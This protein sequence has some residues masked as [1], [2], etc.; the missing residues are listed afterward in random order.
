MVRRGHGPL[1]I[2]GAG[3]AYPSD[4]HGSEA[5]LDTQSASWVLGTHEEVDPISFEERFGIKTREW[6]RP[7]GTGSLELASAA[8]RSA[9]DSASWLPSAVDGLVLAT[10]T[11]SAISKNL[12]AQVAAE[13]GLD[14]FCVDIRAGGAGGLEAWAY[15]AQLAHETSGRIL[16]VAA[17]SASHYANPDDPNNALLFGDG[18]AALAVE[19]LDHTEESPDAGAQVPGLRMV[20]SST[21]RSEGQPFSIAGSLPPSPSSSDR[22]GYRFTA[23]DRTYLASLARAWDEASAALASDLAAFDPGAAG[24]GSAVFLPYAVT[25][26]QLERAEAAVGLSALRAHAHLFRYGCLGA[27]SPLAL[28]ADW[29]TSDRSGSGP[30]TLASLAVGG[31]I[32]KCSLV[33][34]T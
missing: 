17:E 7:F 5:C 34:T 11:P 3:S 9:L 12:A 18:A 25:R 24:A 1:R 15:G 20:R 32:S 28:A 33:W 23:P 6:C 31:G 13:L 22:G 16:V 8:V 10:C 30:T 19:P 21:S 2:A 29:F 26:G 4:L 27:A 14:A